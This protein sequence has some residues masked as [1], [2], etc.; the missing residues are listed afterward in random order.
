MLQLLFLDLQKADLVK[1]KYDKQDDI[2]LWR[3]EFF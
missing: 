3:L 1:K 2:C